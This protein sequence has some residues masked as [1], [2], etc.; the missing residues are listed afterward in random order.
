M[1]DSWIDGWRDV[2]ED[3]GL[4]VTAAALTIEPLGVLVARRAP[5]PR[6]D[7]GIEI[8][9][10]VPDRPADFEKQR[11]VAQDPQF[12]QSLR[13]DAKI[14]SRPFRAQDFDYGPHYEDSSMPYPVSA[15]YLRHNEEPGG[16]ELL[17]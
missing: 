2:G 15:G 12:R 6:G 9:L 10:L 11:S 8:G 4:N 5:R 14:F 16:I 13:A 3:G 17:W 7:P 1:R